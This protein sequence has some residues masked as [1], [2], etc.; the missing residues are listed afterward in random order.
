MQLH[1]FIHHI[2]LDLHSDLQNVC[3]Y[4]LRMRKYEEIIRK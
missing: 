2:C 3:M 4:D 1:L